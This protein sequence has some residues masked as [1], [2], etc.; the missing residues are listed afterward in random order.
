M[1]IIICKLAHTRERNEE[2]E[3]EEIDQT[4]L[5]Q[6]GFSLINTIRKHMLHIYIICAHRSRVDVSLV[7]GSKFYELKREKHRD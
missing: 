5:C 7:N 1:L 2:E 3:E 4:S 6:T